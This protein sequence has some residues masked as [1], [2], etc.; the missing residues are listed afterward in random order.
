M[1][2][3]LVGSE[4]RK[5]SGYVRKGDGVQL[6]LGERWHFRVYT[7]NRYASRFEILMGTPGLPIVGL[8]YGIL[9]LVCTDLTCDRDETNT[10]Y[11]DVVASFD[12]GTEEQQQDPNNPNSQD[13]TTWIPVW[14]GE[15]PA[16]KERTITQ[17][18][19]STPLKCVNS[20]GTPFDQPFSE[21]VYLPQFSF[22]QFED[23]GTT[24]QTISDRNDCVNSAT[25]RSYGARTLLC[26]VTS[27]EIGYYGGFLARRVGYT[28]VYD[29]DTHDEKR[30]DVG[31][32]Y[33][34]GGV[35]VPYMD[36]TNTYPIIGPLNKAGGKIDVGDGLP[37]TLTFKLKREI[38]FTFIRT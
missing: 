25:F 2:S 21:T 33:L 10:S 28:I 37:A 3:M 1:A 9:N 36:S 22:T 12:T 19:S 35:Q 6:T 38:P 29:R 26:T 8:S 31:P 13:P 20:A 34:A 15:A 5:G 17:D 4:L 7:D 32:M 11:W 14:K 27:N 18:R 30:L 16:T 24:E 23:P